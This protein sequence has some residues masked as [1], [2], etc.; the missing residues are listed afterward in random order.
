VTWAQLWAFLASLP[1][2][3]LTWLTR[4]APPVVPAPSPTPAPIDMLAV[5]T[6]YVES[7]QITAGPFPGTGG[8][9][10]AN[11]PAQS[12]A[13]ASAAI[14]LAAKYGIKL[15][16]LISYV[17]QESKGS[18]LA[19]DPND[20]D[21]VPGETPSQAFA[22]TDIGIAQL[23]GAT[24]LGMPEFANSTIAE[25][26]AKAYDP[27]WSLDQM[28]QIIASNTSQMTNAFA[29]DASLAKAVPGGDIRIAIAN[30]YN[31]GYTGTINT[32]RSGAPQ[33][34]YGEEVV[35]RADSLVSLLDA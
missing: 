7:Q 8:T 22:H 35:T 17:M 9:L 26:E 32:L 2:T 27:A 5:L 29:V 31:S 33:L 3:I 30:C 20:S 34:G 25:I 28:C 15:S 16:M 23:D 13:V 10:V 24:L 21:A 18:V 14:A 19:I 12:A 1:A 4:P 11:T 6:Q